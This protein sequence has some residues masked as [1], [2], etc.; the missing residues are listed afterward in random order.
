MFSTTDNDLSD[1]ER[2][3]AK[4]AGR[5]PGDVDKFLVSLEKIASAMG[6]NLSSKESPLLGRR[7]F[8]FGVGAD[9]QEFSVP[10]IRNIETSRGIRVGCLWPYSTFAKFH[11]EPLIYMSQKYV[12]TD[13]APS[14]VLVISQSIISDKYQIEA[15]VER[16]MGLKNHLPVIVVCAVSTKEVA[17]SIQ[18]KF[19]NV[20]SFISALSVSADNVGPD[21]AELEELLDRREMKFI[22]RLARC[23]FDR[24]DASDE[25]RDRYPWI[26]QRAS[27]S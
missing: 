14:E 11:P 21:Y 25:E 12:E 16:A 19:P 4:G 26:P 7:P 6:Q 22:P 13:P 23:L 27:Y 24:L 5:E 20:R 17:D 1:V 18:S 2:F 9:F 10:L 8:V 15:V 3:L